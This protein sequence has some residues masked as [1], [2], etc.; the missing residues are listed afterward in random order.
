MSAPAEIERG[1]W[2]LRVMPPQSWSADASASLV[3][4]AMEAAAP[5]AGAGAKNVR[6]SRHATTR[7]YAI[8][9]TDGLSADVF[10][11]VFDR[12][13]GWDAIKRAV[14]GSRSTRLMAIAA[15]LSAQGFR[16]APIVLVGR[17]NRGGRE[18]VATMRVAGVMV[19]RHLG[20]RRESLA[21]KRDVLAALGAEV[22]RFHNAGFIH[23]DLT[24]FNIIVE[25]AP[26]PTFAF[27]D[28]DGTRQPIIASRRARHRNLVQLG[29]FALA[30]LTASDR[31][32]VWR[33]YAAACA[34]TPAQMRRVA[35]MIVRRMARDAAASRAHEGQFVKDGRLTE[36]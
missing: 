15:R 20:A 16:V 14:R 3:A 34:A 17:E 31:M 23:G 12:P 7:L 1:G 18:M 26:S 6:R 5:A 8:D 4:R 11:K 13:R 35:K 36:G 19:P 9:L 2:R 28:L 21:R 32:R 10:V 24:P 29:H 33:G 22:G 30:G 27:I 25:P